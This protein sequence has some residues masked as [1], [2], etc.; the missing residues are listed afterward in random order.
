MFWWLMI[1]LALIALYINIYLLFFSFPVS[2]QVYMFAFTSFVLTLFVYTSAFFDKLLYICLS[3]S[4][5]SI[6]MCICLSYL[7]SL[8]LFVK[9]NIHLTHKLIV[10]YIYTNI[11]LFCMYNLL[12][13]YS[14]SLCCLITI[15]FY[16]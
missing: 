5:S 12:L 3:F 15:K 11:F 8:Y 13:S 16:Y 2:F 7:S 14:L 6:S 10:L 1:L 9:L 4:L